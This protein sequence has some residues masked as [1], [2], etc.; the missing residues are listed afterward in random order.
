MCS[1]S[2]LNEG[3]WGLHIIKLSKKPL[4][5]CYIIHTHT[6]MVYNFISYFFFFSSLLMVFCIVNKKDK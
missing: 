2:I 6:A 4:C 3:C 1:L 5:N